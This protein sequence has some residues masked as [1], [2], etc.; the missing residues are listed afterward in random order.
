MPFLIRNSYY[1][2]AMT[3]RCIQNDLWLDNLPLL[4]GYPLELLI[5]S[6]FVLKIVV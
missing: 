3:H 2:F 4:N 6:L 1:L 5:F